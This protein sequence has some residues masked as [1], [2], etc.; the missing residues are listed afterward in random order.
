[1][2]DDKVEGAAL[3]MGTHGPE[4]V[5]LIADGYLPVDLVTG[6]TLYLL[7][8]QP[9]RKS[10]NVSMPGGSG[11]VAGGV[12]VRERFSIHQPLRRTDAFTVS[13]ASVGRHVHK[14]RRY[15][16]TRSTTVSEDGTP[17]AVNLTTGLLAYRVDDALADGEE[18]VAPQDL[19]VPGPNRSAARANPCIPALRA[20]Q[21]GGRMG[22]EPVGVSLAM[23]QARD[24]RRPD[25]P[26]HSDPELA[27][28]AGLSRPIAGGSH[29]LAFVLEPVLQHV[30]RMAL[31]HGA[32]FDI[33]WKAPVHSDTVI[34]PLARVVRVDDCAVIE[35]SAHLEDNTVAMTGVV[36]VPLA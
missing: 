25:N 5:G 10:S 1:M 14:G 22:G 2:R 19:V 7:A 11:G 16:T 8:N 18:G 29:V 30:G 6:L 12:W 13:G 34:T 35:L 26:I 21:T 33:R 15:G 3:G 24:T 20:L 27:R 9:R 28:Q 32:A 4:T 36:T 17:V 23:M 31:F